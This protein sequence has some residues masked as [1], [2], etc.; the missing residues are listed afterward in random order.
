MMD[1]HM[2][3]ALSVML[4]LLA[5]CGRQV[6]KDVP[7]ALYPELILSH[8]ERRQDVG[9]KEQRILEFTRRQRLSGVLITRRPDFDWATSGAACSLPLFFRDDGRKFVI[10]REDEFSGQ[11]IQD[12]AGLGFESKIIPWLAGGSGDLWLGEAVEDLAGER[13]YGADSP[14]PGARDVSS[15]IA[16]LRARLT[17]GELREYRWLGRTTAEAV[18]GVC[19]RIQPGM[20]DRGL[21]A[22]LIDLLTRRAIHAVRTDVEADGRVIGSDGA[23]RSDVSKVERRASVRACA[24]R[25]GLRIELTRC[26]QFGPISQTGREQL[27]AAAQVN[28]GYWARTLPGAL[29]G[30]I[31]EGAASDY[32]QAG[33]PDEATNHNPGGPIGYECPDW[34]PAPGSNRAVTVPQAYAWAATIG[35]TRVEDTILLSADRMEVLTETPDWPRIES[36]S[37]GKIYRSPSILER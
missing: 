37:L 22:L 32:R 17:E 10:A 14:F 35:A 1:T 36:K 7:A 6:G 15:E 13:P 25:W 24:E 33:F 18:E 27:K 23:A 34:V 4:C 11:A 5:A 21:E 29:S 26:V 2:R 9:I 16:S 31:L 28:A 3:P 19:R 30:A 8:A 20:T 12:L